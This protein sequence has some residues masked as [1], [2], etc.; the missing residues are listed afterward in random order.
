MT[1]TVVYTVS[2]DFFFQNEKKTPLTDAL[3]KFQILY[4]I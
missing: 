3:S 4:G 1:R 2:S